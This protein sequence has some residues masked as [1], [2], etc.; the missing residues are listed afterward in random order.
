MGDAATAKTSVAKSKK[1]TRD[2]FGEGLRELGNLRPEVVAVSG[3][4]GDSTRAKWFGD[5]H[6]ERF[7]EVG[8]AEQNLVSTAAGLALTGKIPFANSFSAFITGRAW[9]QI[10]ISVC[11]MDANV[12][13]VGSH[14]GLSVGPDGATA[15]AL[16]DIA[17]MRILPRMTVIVP[18]DAEQARA[19]TLALG[20][21]VGPAYLRCGRAPVPVLTNPETEF[22]IGKAR[23]AREGEDLTL[24]ACGVTVYFALLAAEVLSREGIEARVLDM[25]TIKP[26]DTKALA[27]AAE[28]TGA[29]LSV[30]EHTIHGGLGG[31][32]AEWLAQNANV[33]FKIMGVP[34]KFGQSGE[35]EELVEVYGLGPDSIAKE[36][37]KICARK[38]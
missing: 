12:K 38:G 3:D 18:C 31:A 22:E 24:V 8:I 15:E 36:A 6:P 20:D 25:H 11:Y 30:E 34:D 4:L 33:P 27:A 5:E 1:P 17:A 14:G 10:R 19:A 28:E 21:H 29:L 16:E 37:R 26:L 2:G 9:E 23:L 13:I 7:F 32:I 35:F